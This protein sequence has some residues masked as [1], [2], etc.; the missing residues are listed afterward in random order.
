MLIGVIVEVLSLVPSLI[1]IQLFRHIRPRGD[2]HGL[3]WWCLYPTYALC[4]VLVGISV[5]FI[6]VRGIEFGDEKVQ[7]WLISILASFFSSILLT[8]PLKV[9]VHSSRI[10][11]MRSMDRLI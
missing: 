8:Q 10:D 7:Q 6:V 2:T 5:F 11:R 9:G 3:P 4:F 1:V